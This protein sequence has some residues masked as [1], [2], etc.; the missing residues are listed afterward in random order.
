MSLKPL[1]SLFA[2]SVDEVRERERTALDALLGHKNRRVVLFGAGTLGK[3]AIKL[4]KGIDCDILAFSDNGPAAC[5]TEI[6]GIP[7]LTP[8]KAAALYGEKAVFLGYDLE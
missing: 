3:R 4:L 5:G 2:E 1:C 7:V 6:D 8:E